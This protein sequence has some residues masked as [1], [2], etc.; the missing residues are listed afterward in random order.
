MRL[1]RGLIALA[2]AADAAREMGGAEGGREVKNIAIIGA[3]AA[4]SSAAYHLHKYAHEANLILNITLFEK[5]DH[6]GGR[7]LTVNPFDD[8]QQRVELGASIFIKDNR[9][10]YNA[11]QTFGL[12]LS[13]RKDSAP[14]DYTAIWD[15]ETIV[16]RSEEGTPWWW[17]AAKLFLKYG[18]APYKAM[19]LVKRSVGT[20]LQLYE[21]P[22]FPF[23]SL[24]QRVFELGLVQLTGVTGEEILQENKINADFV[25]DLMQPATRVNYASNVAFIH[26]LE[27][28]VSFATEGAISI[29]GGN[30]Q[31]FEKMVHCSGASY[32]PNTTVSTISFHKGTNKPGSIPQY[33][34]STKDAS[35]NAKPARLSTAFDS[36]IIASPWQ[37]SGMEASEG[38]MTHRID[39]IPYM[40]LHVTLFA[41]PFKLHAPYFGLKP[42]TAAPRSVYTTLGKDEAAQAGPKGVG[43]TGFYAMS[44]LRKVTNP[45]TH[46]KEYL[47]KIFSAE[48]VNSTF[49]SAILGRDVPASIVAAN[50][51]EADAEVGPISWYYPHWFYSYPIALPRVTFQDPIVGR[52]VYYTSGMESFIST[53][54]T[55]ALMGMNVA[56]LIVDDVMGTAAG[57]ANGGQIRKGLG[58]AAGAGAREDFWDSMDSEIGARVGSLGA[59]EL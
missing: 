6:I 27:A 1:F 22:Y 11:T 57:G 28:I 3:G 25:R 59:D 16:F 21:A 5:T 58:V 39:A 30:Y 41:S 18:I 4:G 35:S 2:V 37:Y 8:P 19:Q 43:R 48:A 32:R 23:R 56:R 36:V 33:V 14:T 17:N 24:T 45:K 13:T 44:T 7:T 38:V 40:K 46:K 20:F 9:I 51:S 31:I 52:G 49:L 26:G 50:T 47:Y 42:G 15:G 55:N 53:M 54:E 34:L 12:N 10:M 29:S